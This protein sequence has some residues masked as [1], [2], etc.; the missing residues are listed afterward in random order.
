MSPLVLLSYG[1]N[2]NPLTTAS[3]V[4]VKDVCP[5]FGKARYLP[6]SRGASGGMKALKGGAAITALQM[7][8]GEAG[9]HLCRWYPSTLP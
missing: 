2:N 3:T 4:N 1:R 9:L 6:V 8:G 5:C 7:N